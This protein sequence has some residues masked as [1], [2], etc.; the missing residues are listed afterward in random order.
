MPPSS[1]SVNVSSPSR[2][3]WARL[4][5]ARERDLV[6]RH[7]VFG[8]GDVGLDGGLQRGLVDVGLDRLWARRFRA[9]RRGC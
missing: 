1:L 2:T 4:L 6:R 8:V 9:G 3:A 7:P 5:G